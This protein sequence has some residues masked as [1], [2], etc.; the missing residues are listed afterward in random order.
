MVAAPLK[1]FAHLL[2]ETLGQLCVVGSVAPR[3]PL[4][5]GQGK[6]H[7]SGTRGSEC[8]YCFMDAVLPETKD[9]VLTEEM[10]AELAEKQFAKSPYL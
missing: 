1:M 3:P 4:P 8:P 10:L 7:G 5:M 9:Y 6:E 2:C